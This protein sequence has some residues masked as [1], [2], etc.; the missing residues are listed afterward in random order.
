MQ[1]GDAATLTMLVPFMYVHS[2]SGTALSMMLGGE[3][4][5][6]LDVDSV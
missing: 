1:T 4:L 6:A 3:Y 2:D 5:E